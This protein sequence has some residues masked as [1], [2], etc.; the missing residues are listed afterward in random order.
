MDHLG[1]ADELERDEA[2]SAVDVV[3]V[4]VVHVTL[5][6][7]EDEVIDLSHVR[8][9]ARDR[10]RIGKV[11]AD[12]AGAAADLGRG[13]LGSGLVSSRH[14]DV[15]AVVGVRL[16]EFATQ[17]L[18]ATDDDDVPCCHSLSPL[19]GRRT[20]RQRLCRRQLVFRPPSLSSEHK[21]CADRG[22]N[23]SNGRPADR[24]LECRS[25]CREPPR[26]AGVD[27]A[28]RTCT[29]WTPGRGTPLTVVLPR[30]DGPLTARG[31]VFVASAVVAA[32]FVPIWLATARARDRR[33]D[34]RARYAPAYVVGVRPSR[35]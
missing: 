32:R 24:G 19:A 34:H 4:N 10:V 26:S 8:E 12:S 18:R 7:G 17:S 2:Q 22:V 35:T 20:P 25:A 1:V 9:A 15:V 27:T 28:R 11:E 16:R 13:R 33:R 31:R 21:R 29:E 6:R 5:D 3:L 14:D 23:A 30:K